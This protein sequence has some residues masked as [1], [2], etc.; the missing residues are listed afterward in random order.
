MFLSSHSI[1]AQKQISIPTSNITNYNDTKVHMFK[2]PSN[3][4]A[5]PNQYSIGFK[6]L[7]NSSTLINTFSTHLS[8]NDVKVIKK[9]NNINS[10]TIQLPSKTNSSGI[11]SF[12]LNRN[13]TLKDIQRIFVPERES[14]I[15]PFNATSTSNLSEIPATNST[16]V[17]EIIKQN[18]LIRYCEPN[19]IIS[20]FSSDIYQTLPIDI[21][22]IGVEYSKEVDLINMPINIA[23][24]DSGIYHHKDLNVVKDISFVDTNVDDCGH[25]TNVAGIIAAKNNSIGVMGVAPGVKLWSIKVMKWQFNPLDLQYECYGSIDNIKSGLDFVLNNTDSIDVV[26]LSDGCICNDTGIDDLINKIVN[27]GVIVVTA[28]GNDEIDLKNVTPAH[29]PNAISVSAISDT[30]GI[31]GGKGNPIIAADGKNNKDDFYA[32]FS[33]FG[34]NI[35]IAAPGIHINSTWNDG[36]YNWEDG[37]SQAAPHVTGA[38]ALLKLISKLLHNDGSANIIKKELLSLAINPS[39][40]MC[41]GKAK[42]Y[43]NNSPNIPKEPLLYVKP[44]IDQIESILH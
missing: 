42:G 14:L 13:F 36:G 5:I 22:R 31:C 7:N 26:N 37:T 24:I 29:N 38:V 18:N 23:V 8:E 33:N 2:V 43:F 17:C 10:I 32:S 6:G 35:T 40:T 25:G 12:D 39:F 30:D 27:K 21:H 28:V 11:S 9:F 19:R 20:P 44:I 1:F 3:G 34:K 41:D 15:S 4:K 16:L